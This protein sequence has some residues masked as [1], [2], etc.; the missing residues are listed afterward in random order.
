[1]KG[2]LLLTA[3]LLAPL[4]TM[5]GAGLRAGA[6][7]VD[8]T[9]RT[10]GPVNDPCFAKALVLQNDETTAVLVTMDAVSIGEIG[11]VDGGFLP[12]VRPIDP[13]IGLLR[14]DRMDGSILAVLDNFACHPIMN[15]PSK[16]S[17]ADFPGFASRPIEESLG[18]EAMAFFIQ[19]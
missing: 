15:P 2:M 6:A 13:Q 5:H 4:A 16:G 19:G 10:A 11:R 17:S 9:D 7:G 14:L 12:A 1:M 8:I 3:V 18:G